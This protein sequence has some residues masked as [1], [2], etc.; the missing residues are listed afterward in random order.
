MILGVYQ[1]LINI[2]FFRPQI[3]I[4]FGGYITVPILIISHIFRINVFIHEGNSVVGRANKLLYIICKKMF[5]VYRNRFSL[6]E[7]VSQL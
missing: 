7:N 1:S 4:G 5:L 2:L 3:S 6:I